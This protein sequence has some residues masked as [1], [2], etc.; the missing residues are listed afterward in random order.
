M[1]HFGSCLTRFDRLQEAHEGLTNIGVRGTIKVKKTRRKTEDR[2]KSII[3]SLE[4]RPGDGITTYAAKD[5]AAPLGGTETIC[6]I[7]HYCRT[8]VFQFPGCQL[9]AEAPVPYQLICKNQA[10]KAAV[11]SDLPAYFQQ[12]GSAFPHYTINVSLRDGVDRI[13]R[14]EL[15][16]K[17]APILPIFLVTE[18][19]ESVPVTKFENGECFLI[20]ERRDDKALIT[21][22]REGEQALLAIRTINGVWPDFSPDQHAV[23]TVLAALKVEQN[24]MHH[25]EELNSYSCFVSDDEQAVY[26]VHTK[27][28]NDYGSLRVLSPVDTNGLR[29]TVDGVRSIHDGLLRDSVRKPQ[30]AELIDSILLD[31]TQDDGHFRLWYLRLWQAVVDCK[32]LLGEPRFEGNPDSIAGKLTQG[33]LKEYRDKIAHWWTGCPIQDTHLLWRHRLFF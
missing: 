6:T 12:N 11:V 21:G 26:T 1:S 24:I 19:Y 7:T 17:K 33:G 9:T 10:F 15:S 16:K 13:Y 18:Q 28:G 30:V 8:A 4:R 29:E 32:K 5:V 23:N 27:M 20:D 22:G 31:N 2:K 3:E 25:I 14:K